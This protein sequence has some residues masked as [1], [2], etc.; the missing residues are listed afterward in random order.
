MA[1]SSAKPCMSLYCVLRLRWRAVYL[2]WNLLQ[3]KEL[4]CQL[5]QWQM[6]GYQ[7]IPIGFS[8]SSVP[9]S[10]KY[11]RACPFY[12]VLKWRVL[13]LSALFDLHNRI[14]LHPPHGSILNKH[15]QGLATDQYTL[16][17][18]TRLANCFFVPVNLFL[19][20]KKK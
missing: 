12:T 18:I 16:Q 20:D 7:F 17:S 8:E 5:A 6:L 4:L 2:L 9:G 13:S 3:F 11:L 10:E 19:G 15:T 1:N 14:V